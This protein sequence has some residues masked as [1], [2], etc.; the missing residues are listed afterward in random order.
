M[1]I[2]FGIGGKH[3]ARTARKAGI[4]YVVLEMNPEVL[5]KWID[6]P[7]VSSVL[8]ENNGYYDVDMLEESLERT[9]KEYGDFSVKF[10]GI[11]FLSPEE[12]ELNFSAADVKKLKAYI[13]E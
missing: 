7:V 9:L 3:L 8:M 5:T 4:P 13:N 2:G 12:K 1:I 10:P 11:R 6:H